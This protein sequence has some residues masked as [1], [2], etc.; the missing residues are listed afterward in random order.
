MAG[1]SS[2]A[3]LLSLSKSIDGVV[4]KNLKYE[5]KDEACTKSP[6]CPLQKAP[7]LPFCTVSTS[8]SGQRLCWPI[9]SFTRVAAPRN[10][11]DCLFSALAVSHLCGLRGVKVPDAAKI[12]EWGAKNRTACVKEIRAMLEGTKV[13]TK[14]T[15][16][17]KCPV[18]FSLVCKPC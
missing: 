3:S 17:I 2:S 5:F 18:L 7:V 12:K 6:A 4:L 15:V 13:A 14:C 16:T 1:S 10:N 9:A 11:G 8:L